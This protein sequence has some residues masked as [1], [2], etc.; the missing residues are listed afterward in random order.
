MNKLNKS[1]HHFGSPKRI[2]RSL[3]LSANMS[4]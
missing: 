2:L 3:G 4:W 1:R